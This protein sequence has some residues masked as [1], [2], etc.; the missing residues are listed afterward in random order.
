VKTVYK[1]E[2]W[3]QRRNGCCVS[4]VS[5]KSFRHRHR[6]FPISSADAF[7]RSDRKNDVCSPRPTARQIR[8]LLRA[9]RARGKLSKYVRKRIYMYEL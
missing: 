9:M 7:R 3:K 5:D 1:N 4:V 2:Q 6:L 8:I